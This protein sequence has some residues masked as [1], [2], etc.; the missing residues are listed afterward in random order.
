MTLRRE[1]RKANVIISLSASTAAA[2]R[3]LETLLTAAQDKYHDDGKFLKTNIYK[4][5][6]AAWAYLD[7]E[8]HMS[9]GVM[10]IDDGTYDEFMEDLKKLKPASKVL[11]AVGAKVKA[12]KGRPKKSKL[13]HYMGSL[14]KIKPE[15]ADEWLTKNKGPYVVG[16]KE[17]GV[18]IQL[19]YTAREGAQAFTRGDGE[20]GQDITHLLPHMDVPQSLNISMDIRGEIIMPEAVFNSKWST[21]ALGKKEGFEN[22]R[23]MVSG[24]VNSLTPHP[25]LKDVHVVVYAVLK[26]SGVPSMQLAKL[27]KLGFN[28]VPYK[29]YK[30]LTAK[31]LAEILLLR[32]KNTKRAIDGL[33]VEQD[34][35]VSVRDGVNPDHARAFKMTGIDDIAIVPVKAVVWEESRHGALIPRINI[36]PIRLSGVTVNYTT[37]HNVYFIEHGYRYKERDK[38]LP[39]RPIAPG[40]MI[41][42]TRSGDVIPHIISVEKGAKKPALPT[43]FDYEYTPNGVNIKV[44]KRSNLTKI[45]NIT[46]FFATM[47]IDGIKQGTIQKLYD[48]G[49]DTI[50]KVVKA[51]KAR[52][53]TVDTIQ[54]KT[55]NNIKTNIKTALENAPLPRLMDASG[56]FGSGLGEKRLIPLVKANPN[57]MN[58]KLSTTQLQAMALDVGGFA[59]TLATQFAEGFEKFAAFYARLGITAK[60]PESVKV[61]GAKFKNQVVVFTGVRDAEAA[62]AIEAQGGKLASGVTS[63][64]TMLVAKDKNSTSDS[65]VKA[66]DLDIKIVSHAELRKMLKL[67]S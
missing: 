60:A 65:A 64:V 29:V 31:K 2:I 17:D 62:K 4:N 32:K 14:D 38:G 26:P 3:E 56:C 25:A 52:L 49:L 33:V 39:V 34:R 67:S 47:K 54:E 8:F 57:I 59:K 20:I 37:G 58:M 5:Y 53:L 16:N 11:K 13:K 63:K 15:N 18:S 6:P 7:N 1:R 66:R 28:V 44:K 9:K 10:E 41:K 12:V 19:N 27:A 43:E 40:T 48:D 30:S 24:M 50:L 36:D 61:V 45:K 35:A 51:S 42:I 23:N 22:A 21:A 46:H 55:A